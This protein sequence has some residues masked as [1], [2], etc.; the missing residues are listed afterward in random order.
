MPECSVK[1]KGK[2]GM[3]GCSAAGDGKMR[4][5]E[6]MGGVKGKTGQT[7]LSFVLSKV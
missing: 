2:P 4:K 1:S 3:G 7:A 5:V 6:E